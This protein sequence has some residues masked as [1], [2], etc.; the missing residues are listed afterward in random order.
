MAEYIEREAVKAVIKKRLG[1]LDLFE[2]RFNADID[3]MPT[4]DV[5]E[6]VRCKDCQYWDSGKR[7]ANCEHITSG[8]FVTPR[9]GMGFCSYGERRN[10]ADN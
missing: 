9:D 10:D 6:V 5:V 1:T 7:G 8:L 4:A 2:S 3:A